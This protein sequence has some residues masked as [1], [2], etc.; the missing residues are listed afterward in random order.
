MV[1]Y[2]RED[3]LKAVWF[4]AA[5]AALMACF[6]CAMVVSQWRV[7]VFLSLNLLLLAILFSSS[8]SQSQSPSNETVQ[9]TEEKLI[10]IER[11]KKM[12]YDPLISASDEDHVLE[13]ECNQLSKEELN[14]RVEAFI[15]MF[16]QQYLVSDA[17]VKSCR[18][19]PPSK[20]I[21]VNSHSG[22]DISV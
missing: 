19:P 9:E 14:R 18:T 11:E 6:E 1:E 8:T 2:K 16:R 5:T 10:K 13:K 20:G 22:Y 7:W 3:Q 15:A 12:Q 21:S 17:R 4:A